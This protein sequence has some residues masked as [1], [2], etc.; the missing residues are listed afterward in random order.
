MKVYYRK[1]Y[2][3]DYFWTLEYTWIKVLFLEFRLKNKKY[4]DAEF[5]RKLR[6][7]R[8]RTRI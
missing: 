6:N 2:F 4:T 5:S 1:G 3:F 7:N 8:K